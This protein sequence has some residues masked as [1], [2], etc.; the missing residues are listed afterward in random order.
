MYTVVQSTR[1]L[2]PPRV[3]T[4]GWYRGVRTCCATT[5]CTQRRTCHTSRRTVVVQRRTCHTSP[6]TSVHTGALPPPR[7]HSGTGAYLPYQPPYSGTERCPPAQQLPRQTRCQPARLAT[8]CWPAPARP[9]S[10]TTRCWWAPA[11][12]RSGAPAQTKHCHVPA[13]TCLL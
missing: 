11:P 9:A 1:A 2:P 4:P 8:H 7:V 12:A 5:P 13:R 6:H 10:Q 3:Y